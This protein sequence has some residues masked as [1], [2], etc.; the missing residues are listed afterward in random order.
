MGHVLQ[1]LRQVLAVGA[2]MGVVVDVVVIS[3]AEDMYQSYYQ[4]LMFF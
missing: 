1:K 4:V 2:E 3:P